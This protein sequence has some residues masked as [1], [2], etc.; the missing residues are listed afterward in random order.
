M[1]HF[2]SRCVALIVSVYLINGGVPVVLAQKSSVQTVFSNPAPITVNT[3]SGLTAPTKASLYPSAIEVSGMT[4]NTAR[5]AVTLDG[6]NHTWL[7]N[8][9]FLLVSP[10][11]AKFIFLSDGNNGFPAYEANDN[12]FT[13]ADDAP[14]IFPNGTFVPNGSYRPTSGDLLNDTFPAPAPAGPYNQ[15]NSATFAS[16]FNGSNPNGS[17][18]LYAVDDLLGSAGAVN[19]GWSLTVTTDGA[20]QTFSNNSPIGLNDV[21]EPASPYGSAINVAGV[22]G[23]ISDVNVTINGITHTRANDLDFLLVSPN[24]LGI[25]ILSD[26]GGSASN[27]NVTLDDSAPGQI[28]SYGTGTFQTRNA[29]EEGVDVFPSP[30]PI[31]PLMAGNTLLS[32]FNGFSPNG[33]W[34][35]YV[36]DDEQAISGTV[37]G[38]WSLDIT[39]VPVPPPTGAVCAAPVF[40]TTSAATGINPTN[41]AVADFNN[42]GKS[43]LA[44]TNQ[45]SNDVSILPGNGDGTF[46]SQLLIPAGS[47][48]YAT[49]A[50]K[51]N[52]DNNF[53]L[54]VANSGS[55]NVSIFLGNGNGTFSAPASFFVGSNP[56]SINS[57]D[58]NNDGKK[59]LAVANF[60][61]FFAGTVSVLL[62]NGNGGFAAGTNIRTRSQ[63]SAIAVG[64][65]NSDSNDD[66]VVTN[67]GA[68]SF[69]VF[70]GTGLGT[71]QLLQSISTPSPAAVELA[72]LND[73]NN[74]DIA[75]AN[76]DA[77]AVLSCFGGAGGFFASCFSA[78][79]GFNPISVTSGDFV[80][81]GTN[82]LATALSGANGI[83]L[84]GIDYDV[85]VNPNAVEA[86]DLNNDGKLD[87]VAVNSGS[88]DVSVMINRC[89]GARGNLFDYNGDR[90]T[91]YSAFRPSNGNYYVQSLN[92]SGAA[93]MFGRA[94]DKIAP[95]DFDGDRRTDFAVFRPENG[96]W[97]V[98]DQYS[99]PICFA[100]FGIA[101]D[102][103][104]PAD[105]DGDGKADLAVWRP[106][107]G[108]WY[109]RRSSDNSVQINHFGST[110]DRP[111]A[112]DFDGDNRADLG[113]YRPST[114][115]WYIWRSSDSNV[116]IT[117][118]GLTG[119][120]TVAA[121]YDGDGK[122]D[123]AVWRPSTGAWY[124]LKSSDGGFF[125]VTFGLPTDIPLVGEFNGD[126]RFDYAVFRPS[127]GE[128]YVQ[129]SS[130]SGVSVFQWGANGDVPLPSAYAR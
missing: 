117:Q 22:S 91:D 53:D 92:G 123:I 50:G 112:A 115:V 46:G 47:G 126:G 66:L 12:L 38:G 34:R 86:T 1:W 71:F 19:S 24:G 95:A 73:D 7:S 58:F 90:I 52:S 124:I 35:L 80:G 63:P 93:K 13:F 106:S 78:P 108:T 101:E 64:R 2:V 40:S 109:V 15:P 69:S 45:V 41:L 104:V 44:V 27:A 29:N 130:D 9:D 121:D 99:Q 37:A 30:A 23:I 56:I 70:V 20:S 55:N 6:V 26:I 49:L 103:P 28:G 105:F 120:R 125:A 111:V 48:P 3:A 94:T 65:I 39:T 60:G 102:V 25:V 67:F 76:Y 81:S 128:W 59:D 129:R 10:T 89:F 118:F 88:N 16:T 11:G 82:T 85:G 14:T 72:N 97:F 119:D 4:G 8:L 122:V 33:D 42:D 36:M 21:T 127:T 87:L 96:Y 113:I 75:I 61:G 83:H 51:F 84:L 68:N 17:W 5:I 110:G 98:I 31:R 107:A 43:D 57:G 54:A 62:G 116:Y 100:Q 18:S 74:I 32:S 79:V 114:G 77:D